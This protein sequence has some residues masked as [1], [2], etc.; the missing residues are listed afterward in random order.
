MM[1]CQVCGD[2]QGPFEIEDVKK[3]VLLVC[4]SCAKKARKEQKKNE[5]ASLYNKRHDSRVSCSDR[6]R[7]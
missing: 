5:T 1:Q 3:R 6:R 2:T 7:K 4:E